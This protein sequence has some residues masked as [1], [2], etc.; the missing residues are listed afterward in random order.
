MLRKLYDW[1]LAKA[2]HPHAQWWLALFAFV[3]ASFF[4]I[5]PHPL[6]GLMCLA[7]PDMSILVPVIST[8]ASVRGGMLGYAIGWGT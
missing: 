3:E 1:V 5:P 8:P 7:E 4:P 6:L 2:A